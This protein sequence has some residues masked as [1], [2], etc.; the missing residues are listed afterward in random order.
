MFAA[1]S[2]PIRRQIVDWLVDGGSGTSTEFAARVPISR[3]AVSRHLGELKRAG[4]VVSTKNGREVRYSLTTESM[5]EAMNWISQRT[6]MW[7]SA[8]KRL[9]R[10]VSQGKEHL[11][12]G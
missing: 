8:L 6:T 11:Y 10:H 9:K 1:L 5:T 3:Q 7:D 12:R 4:V 2:D